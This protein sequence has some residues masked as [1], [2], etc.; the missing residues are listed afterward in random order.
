M[1]KLLNFVKDFSRWLH[2]ILQK[3]VWVI[4][5]PLP[6]L[7]ALSFYVPGFP[8]INISWQLSLGVGISGIVISAF[9]VYREQ[10]L[11]LDAFLDNA[12]QYVFQVTDLSQKICEGDKIHIDCNVQITC[13]TIWVG[14]LDNIRIEVINLPEFIDKGEIS[15]KDY[16]PLDWHCPNPLKLP[17]ELPQNG[18]D[19]GLEIHFEY[20]K[21]YKTAKKKPRGD[22]NLFLCFLIR[23]YTPGLGYVQKCERVSVPLNFDNIKQSILN[24][25]EHVK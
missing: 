2:L 12:P 23:Y 22:P 1:P 5:L 7:E 9:L 21:E 4:G 3:W 18:V 15:R 16:Q 10:K 14:V 24:T 11:H 17:Y 20:D 6:I 25:Q 8:Q 19:L 13:K